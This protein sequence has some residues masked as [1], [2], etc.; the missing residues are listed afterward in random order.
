MNRSR[1]S[2]D[3]SWQ[4]AGHPFC[5]PRSTWP[6]L[7]PHLWLSLKG[8]GLQSDVSR[9]GIVAGA[10]AQPMRWPRAFFL[11]WIGKQ[12]TAQHAMAALAG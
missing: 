8:R 3:G 9:T 10:G 11:T 1:M 5:Q 7:P 12:V 6:F 2:C 4:R